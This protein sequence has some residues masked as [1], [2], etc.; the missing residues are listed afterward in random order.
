MLTL[1]QN[2]HGHKAIKEKRGHKEKETPKDIIKV[3]FS[4]GKSLIVSR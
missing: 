2:K 4:K 3:F 1:K